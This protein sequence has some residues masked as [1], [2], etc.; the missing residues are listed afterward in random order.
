MLHVKATIRTLN[1]VRFSH[2][3]PMNDESERSM[4]GP[5]GAQT[6][7]FNSDFIRFILRHNTLTF[8][9]LLTISFE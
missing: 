4:R 8:L 9:Q 6:N 7:R 5:A 1:K 2:E 3:E